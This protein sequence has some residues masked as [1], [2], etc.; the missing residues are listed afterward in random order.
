[1]YALTDAAWFRGMRTRQRFTFAEELLEKSMETHAH[2]QACNRTHSES[3]SSNTSKQP[4]EYACEFA[5]YTADM[6]KLALLGDLSDYSG[7]WHRSEAS[8]EPLTI[9]SL[10]VSTAPLSYQMHRSVAAMPFRVSVQHL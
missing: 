8:F 3:S 2:E 6:R 1:M 7:N 5:Q 9:A 10:N 4:D